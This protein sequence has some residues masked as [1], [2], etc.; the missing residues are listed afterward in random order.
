M[1]ENADL[2]AMVD[3]A[4]IR[5]YRQRALTPERPTIRGTA[6]N[7][8]VYFQARETVNPLYNAMPAIVQQTMDRFAELTGRAYRLFDYDGAPDA[9][10]VVVVMGSG[11]ETAR[12]TAHFLNAAGAKVGVVTVRLYRPFSVE[13]FLR[14]LPPTV[15]TIAVLDRT[16]EPGS[17]GE[18]LYLDVVAALA[19]GHS[20]GFS[21][22]P[23]VIGGRYGLSSKE[24]T[25]A[26]VRGIY[27]ALERLGDGSPPAVPAHFT[28]G[29]ND[30]LN[31]TS[32]PYN[33]AFS[34]ESD[35]TR[36]CVF[37]GLGADGTVGA[38]KN[39]IKIIGDAGDEQAPIYAQGY[40][41]Y[42]SKKS[43]S[44]TVSHLRFGPQPIR[45][46]YLIESA[47][48]VACHQFA[49][50]ERFDVLALARPGAIFLLNAPYGPTA[51]WNELPREVQQTIREK[52]LRLY[53]IDAQ[54]VAGENGMGTRI[55]TVMQTCFFAISGVMPRE[56]AIAAIKKTIRTTYGK[57]G[58]A[59]VAQN[60]AAVDAALAHPH[61]GDYRGRETSVSAF[62]R[63]P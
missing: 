53:V 32:L 26:M 61:A 38:N 30:D 37:Y 8:D 50:L 33:P 49:F 19:E 10:H 44:L 55:N 29:I 25:P 57:R 11:A 2:H 54:R 20:Y 22:T 43:G 7:P 12:E 5:A 63:R 18:P 1:L 28:I 15:R 13:H 45:A 40:F 36:C 9:E 51:I 21:A 48:F 27:H 60:E 62:G 42:D 56:E 47:D 35:S 59:V 41:V 52:Q 6:Q 16:K 24:F 17:A 31:H 4:L 14:A 46:P 58:A 39:S 34:I 23:Q 3:D